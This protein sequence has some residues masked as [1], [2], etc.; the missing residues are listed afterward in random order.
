MYGNSIKSLHCI[1]KGV[2]V[3]GESAKRKIHDEI[4]FLEKVE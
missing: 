2:G 3:V 4:I 1:L